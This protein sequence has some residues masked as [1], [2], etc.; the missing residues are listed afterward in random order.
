LVL[1]GRH[2]GLEPGVRNTLGQVNPP[3]CTPPCPDLRGRWIG[4]SRVGHYNLVPYP[5]PH[6]SRAGALVTQGQDFV[7]WVVDHLGL[8]GRCLGHT[9]VGDRLLEGRTLSL[10]AAAHPSVTQG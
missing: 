1:K 7:T 9:R 6:Y 5:Y 2:L 4:Y 10:G 3:Q 8:E